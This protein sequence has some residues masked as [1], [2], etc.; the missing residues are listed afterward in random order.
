MRCGLTRRVL[1]FS[2]FIEISLA[3]FEETKLSKRNLLVTLGIE[4]KM[5][6]VLENYAE[7][8]RD[9]L[10]FTLR[11]SIFPRMDWPSFMGDL[12]LINRRLANLLT[13]GKLYVD[14]VQHDV[15]TLFGTR[16]LEEGRLREWISREY[17]E[18]LGYRV[19]DTIRNYVQH[20]S[21][22]VHGLSYPGAWEPQDS[23]KQL[24]FG[25]L[26]WIQPSNLR[27]DPKFRRAVLDELEARGE[28]LNLVPFVRE[29]VAAISR[30]HENLRELVK[31]IIEKCKR[32]V[33]ETYT[34]ARKVF[35]DQ[36]AGLSL[37][38]DNENGSVAELVEV[39]RDPI[40]R[41]DAL[42]SKN[43]NLGSLA[44]RYVSGNAL[45]PIP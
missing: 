9:L 38:R 20:R 40:D 3:D 37:V 44:V 35:G 32:T 33:D 5:D 25:I 2:G 13:T 23:P 31:P 19:L 43:Q 15:R 45:F 41:I 21:F 28:K 26:P 18:T 1:G 12:Q 6:L 17:D 34:R 29:Y 39:F 16:S 22:P 42:W 8:E 10:D 4:E 11:Y 24:R 36:L 30:V 14:Q 7:F 27:G